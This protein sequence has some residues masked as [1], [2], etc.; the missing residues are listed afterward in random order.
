M[1]PLPIISKQITLK[2]TFEISSAEWT[3][4]IL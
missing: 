1:N 3:R 2:P 4:R